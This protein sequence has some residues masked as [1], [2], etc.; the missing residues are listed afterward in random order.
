MAKLTLGLHARTIGWVVGLAMMTLTLATVG[1]LQSMTVGDPLT[2]AGTIIDVSSSQSMHVR[3]KLDTG[4]A[5]LVPREQ[6]ER[7]AEGDRV[8]VVQTTS[9]LSTLGYRLMKNEQD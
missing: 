3:V 2:R 1:I 4:D 5:V 8:T 7:L 9:A 6:H